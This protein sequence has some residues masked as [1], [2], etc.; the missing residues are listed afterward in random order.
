MRKRREI[1]VELTS[2][3]DVILIMLFVLLLQARTQ[4]EQA[5]TSMTESMEQ[6]ALLE[7]RLQETEAAKNAAEDERDALSRRILS[8]HLVLEN[9]RI[10]TIS[11]GVTGII[12]AEIENGPSRFIGYDWAEDS[13]ARN[14]LQSFCREFLQS[15]DSRPAFLIFQYDRNRIYHAEYE[16]IAS[17]VQR[18][19]EE[20]RTFETALSTIEADLSEGGNEG[21]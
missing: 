21:S 18:M 14:E 3:L 15:A 11:V 7:E 16:M 12:A 19:R 1:L 10:L 17:V 5:K 20:A 2:L 6:I 4:T 9:S 8:D 13:R